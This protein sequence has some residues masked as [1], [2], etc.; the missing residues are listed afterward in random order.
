MIPK[1]PERVAEE[2]H[3]GI[4]AILERSIKDPR[5]L[6]VTITHVKTS[7]DLK[8]AGVYFTIIGDASATKDALKGFVCAKPF[9]RK[10]L[11]HYLKLRCIPDL[12][13]YYDDS[14]E[15]AFQMSKTLDKLRKEREENP[16]TDRE[17]DPE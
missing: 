2:I 1:R 12:R 13:F 8:H 7:P 5:L 6:H 16:E 17:H 10:E 3:K 15:Y 4:A 9:I 11:V 14:I